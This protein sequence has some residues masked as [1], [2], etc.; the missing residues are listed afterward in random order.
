[1]TE[2]RGNG[3][4]AGGG[5]APLRG[6]GRADLLLLPQRDELARRHKLPLCCQRRQAVQHSLQRAAVLQALG[7]EEHL[8]HRAAGKAT[9]R[10]PGDHRHGSVPQLHQPLVEAAHAYIALPGSS[11]GL[12]GPQIAHHCLL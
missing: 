5:V 1:M 7:V 11:D 4:S 8:D 6:G 12:A 9:A 10:E 2:T 3:R